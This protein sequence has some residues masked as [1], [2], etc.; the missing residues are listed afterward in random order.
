MSKTED[1]IPPGSVK[2]GDHT[3]PSKYPPGR[4]PDLDEAWKILDTIKPGVIPGDAR[5][6]IAGQITG[7][8]GRIRSEAVQ[9]AVDHIKTVYGG[10]YTDKNS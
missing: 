3:Y 10:E 6:F 9:R 5:T 1:E 2:I 7:L 4:D 8:I